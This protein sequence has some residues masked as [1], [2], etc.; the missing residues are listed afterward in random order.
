MNT[1]KL[2]QIIKE[3]GFTVSDVAEGVGINKSTF[4][5]KINSDVNCGFT[6]KEAN[7]IVDFLNLTKDEA[8]DI[9]FAP[10]VA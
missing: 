6:V 3:K 10:N 8:N 7:K 9:F 4:Y 1:L 5:R 2:I